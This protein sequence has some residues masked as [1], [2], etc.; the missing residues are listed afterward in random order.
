M[1]AGPYESFGRGGFDKE[2][3]NG[4]MPVTKYDSKN[5]DSLH[6]YINTAGQEVIPC[7]TY[8]PINS[9]AIN[10]FVDWL[11]HDPRFQDAAARTI[12]FAGRSFTLFS[13]PPPVQGQPR[14]GEEQAPYDRAWYTD[15]LRALV[16]AVIANVDFDGETVIDTE[17]N[18]RLRDILT[19]LRG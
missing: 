2:F 7:G 16:H 8:K 3:V 1:I 10:A 11:G 15:W 4:L 18:N 19:S 12:L 14:I 13:P 9:S 17:Q 6:G 5:Y